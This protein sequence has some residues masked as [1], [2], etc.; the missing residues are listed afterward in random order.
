MNWVTAIFTILPGLISLA[1]KLFGSGTGEIKKSMVMGA[2]QAVSSTM[3]A[4]STG[5]QKT[6]WETVAPLISQAVD[7][8]VDV[9]NKTGWA[10]IEDDTQKWGL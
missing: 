5:G 4:V 3:V 9:A 10:K 2:A 8:A 7:L 1:E 6:T